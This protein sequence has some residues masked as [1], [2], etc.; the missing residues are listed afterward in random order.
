MFFFFFHISQQLFKNLHK[1]LELSTISNTLLC[2][3]YLLFCNEK[4]SPTGKNIF[5][6]PF[7]HLKSYLYVLYNLILLL[8]IL[9]AKM[10]LLLSPKEKFISLC[11]HLLPSSHGPFPLVKHLLLKQ[12]SPVYIMCKT[13]N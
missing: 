10:F 1:L 5:N 6:F 7:L 9:K 4:R 8:L 13:L 2:P 3:L 11:Y 12:T